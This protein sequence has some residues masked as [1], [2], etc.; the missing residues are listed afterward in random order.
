MGGDLKGD[1]RT[2]HETQQQ[3]KGDRCGWGG[4]RE[5]L[6]SLHPTIQVMMLGNPQHQGGQLLLQSSFIA[7]I[8]LPAHLSEEHELRVINQTE[9]E[10]PHTTSAVARRG[11]KFVLIPLQSISLQLAVIYRGHMEGKKKSF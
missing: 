3:L 5:E 2:C 9:V 8:H 4:S 10:A 6:I 11:E 1:I 7:S